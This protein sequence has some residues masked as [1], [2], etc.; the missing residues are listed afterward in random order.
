MNVTPIVAAFLEE[1]QGRFPHIHCFGHPNTNKNEIIMGKANDSC[2]AR[3]TFVCERVS[4]QLYT[5]TNLDRYEEFFY[6][7]D[8]DSIEK[9]ISTLE[10]HFKPDET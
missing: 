2:M 1:L 6:L 9:I 8:P 7:G 3:L 10:A 5:D 4:A